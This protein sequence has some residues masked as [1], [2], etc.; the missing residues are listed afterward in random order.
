[1]RIL[2]LLM[3]LIADVPLDFFSSYC[4]KET[5]DSVYNDCYIKAV[6]EFGE[7]A[8]TGTYYLMADWAYATSL[9]DLS[10]Y[11]L[12]K[13]F[14]YD[15]SDQ[16]LR[17]DCLSL[18]SAVARLKGDLT[19]AIKYAEDC[20]EID[21]QSGIAENISSSLN[22]IAG[23]YMTYDD[24]ESARKYIDEA[25]ALEKKLGRSG[26][27]AIRYGVASEIYLHLGLNEEALEFVD[28]AFALD[29]LDNRSEKIAVR[30]SQ[31]AEVLMKMERWNEAENQLEMAVSV[32]RKG[33]SLNSLAI[34]LAQLGEIRMKNGRHDA[35][36]EAF[37]E[38]VNVCLSSGNIFIESRA[39][40]GLWQLNRAS[41][42]ELALTHL[43]RCVDLKSR[44]ATKETD[45][46]MRLFN[47][48]YET[49]KREQ[50]IQLQ[51]QRLRWALICVVLLLTLL[52]LSVIMIVLKMKAANAVERRNAVLIQ[53]NIDKER[54][55]ALAKKDIPA[56]VSSEIED[57]VARQVE[58]PRIHLTAREKEIAEMCAKGKLSKEIAAEL[59]ISPRTVETHK[60]N[61]FKKLGINNT[62]ELMRY[63]QMVF[64]EKEK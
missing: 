35:A 58:L 10:Q 3:L 62:V 28:K 17:A 12:D 37:N 47:V 64:A 16:V 24:A 13:A 20:L 32:F 49:L 60:N 34:S 27:L 21:R 63:M 59:G 31:K 41:D 19:A 46:Q 4:S 29:S 7:D 52:I 51:R 6:D 38:C 2:F 33:N 25:L 14:D 11:C 9:L 30:R 5:V 57:I 39:R 1:M 45:E 54:L 55:L 56:H 61:L 23:L 15:I 18:S 44:L 22:N 53:A 36:D 26:Y 8:P 43:E 42:P 48:K 40:E 50:T